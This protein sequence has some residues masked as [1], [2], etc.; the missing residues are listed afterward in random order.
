[1][2]GAAFAGLLAY[3]TFRALRAGEIQLPSRYSVGSIV[4]RGSA[5]GYFWTTICFYLSVTIAA[6][7]VAVSHARS[8]I[9]AQKENSAGPKVK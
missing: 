9:N 5:P 4:K 2:I 3:G 7:A 8:L 6:A 1:V